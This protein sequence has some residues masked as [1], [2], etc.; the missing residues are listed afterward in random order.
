ML[1]F[2]YGWYDYEKQKLGPV[3]YV[4]MDMDKKFKPWSDNDTYVVERLWHLFDEADIIIGQNHERFDIRKANERFFIHKMP[5]PAPYMTVDLKKHYSRAFAGSASLRYMTRKAD[6][7]LKQGNSGWEM[8]KGC[9]GGVR[10]YWKE[11]RT[12]NIADV[13]ATAELYTEMLPWIGQLGK[14]SHPNMGHWI[15]SDDG[16]VCPN[17]GNKSKAEGGKGFQRR[18]YYYTAAYRYPKMLCLSCGSYR[19]NYQAERYSRTQLR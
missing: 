2:A 15:K 9:M 12:Y 19:K 11:M 18:G 16:F 17:C 10:K 13:V 14:P 5:P 1:S 4:G 8:W 3:Q 6:V 7:A